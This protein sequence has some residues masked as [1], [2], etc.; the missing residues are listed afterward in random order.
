MEENIFKKYDIRGIV[1][2]EMPI[3]ST[4]NIAKAITTFFLKKNPKIKN[5]LVGMDGRISSEKIKQQVINAVTDSGLNVI[6]IGLCPVPVF[7]FCLFSKKEC[8]SGIMVS[9]SH[10]PKEYNGMK[11]CLDKKSLLKKQILEIKKIFKQKKFKNK[12]EKNGKVKKIDAVNKYINW[13]VKNFSNL[14]NLE[15]PAVIDCANGTAG[16]ILPDLIKKM[17]WKNIKLL[18]EKVD[19]NFPNHGPDPTNPKSMKA[20]FNHLKTNKKTEF[21]IG[22]DSDSDRMVLVNKD[23]TIVPGDKLLAIFSKPIAQKNTGAKIVFD[24]K[25]SQGLIELLKK[26]KAKPI[27]SPTGY[28]NIKNT[29]LKNNALA[30]GELSCHFFFNDKYFGFD[31]GIY[32]MLRLFEIIY[33]TQKTVS[34][35]LEEFPKKISSPEY[36]IPCK[37]TE[38]NMIVKNVKNYFLNKKNSKNIIIDGI[39]AQL[40]YGWGLVRASNT[41]SVISLR[42]ESDTKK[43]FNKIKSDFA[44][45]LKPYIDVSFLN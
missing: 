32:A 12:S 43:G 28:S 17:N 10:N 20:V 14:K 15:I 16:T 30:G 21:G 5:I 39:R 41:Q 18:Y 27:M 29:I 33:K 31:D 42:L 3:E 44:K 13:L 7:Y 2:K 6:D 40:S 35:L 34:E 9:A 26:W 25:S 19:G 22:F 24:I 23:C 4:Y 38:K 36:R 8:S 37:E 45:A 11:I 1:G